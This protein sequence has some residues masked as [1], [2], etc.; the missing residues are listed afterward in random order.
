MM[1]N[2]IFQQI[3]STPSDPQSEGKG[4][5]SNEKPVLPQF[6]SIHLRL[7]GMREVRVGSLSHS[8]QMMILKK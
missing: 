4:T 1:T 8:S 2:E 6:L 3:P 7:R 5:E